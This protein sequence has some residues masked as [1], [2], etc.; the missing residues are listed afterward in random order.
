MNLLVLGEDDV[1]S[2]F[3]LGVVFTA[4]LG[5]VDSCALRDAESCSGKLGCRNGQA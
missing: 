3:L 5:V 2:C 1:V 4:L